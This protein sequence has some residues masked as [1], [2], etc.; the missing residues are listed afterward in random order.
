MELARYMLSVGQRSERPTSRSG[1]GQWPRT[2][3]SWKTCRER[4]H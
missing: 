2:H 1:G 3:T 4:I